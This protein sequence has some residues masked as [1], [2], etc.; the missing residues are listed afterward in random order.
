MVSLMFKQLA[1]LV[2]STAMLSAGVAYGSTAQ[3]SSQGAERANLLAQDT[4]ETE[5]DAYPTADADVTYVTAD[6][7]CFDEEDGILV[8]DEVFAIEYDD[9]IDYFY[10]D[11][12][13]VDW[14][15]VEWDGAILLTDG[16]DYVEFSLI[17]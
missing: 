8:D 15:F 1:A 10:I 17:D 11:Y 16:E 3:H 7:T 13:G 12:D 9:A 6:T 14:Y 5:V 4:C 2:A